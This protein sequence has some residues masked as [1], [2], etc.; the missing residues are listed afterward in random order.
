MDVEPVTIFAW[1]GRGAGL[2]EAAVDLR[3]ME[4]EDG[5]EIESKSTGWQSH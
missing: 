4:E 3:D 1:R 2:H 5:E